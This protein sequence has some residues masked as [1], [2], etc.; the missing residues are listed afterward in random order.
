MPHPFSI[1]HFCP[2]CGS[3]RFVV[4]NAKSKRCEACGFVY[5]ANPQAATVG[6][7][8]N[9]RGELLVVRRAKD[10]ARGTLDL[11]GGFSDMGETSE[12]GVVRE[13]REETGLTVSVRR[14]LFSLPNTYMFSGLLEH[15]MDMFYL[16]DVVGAAPARAADD[17]AEVLWLPLADLDPE[18]FGLNSI[19]RAIPK[20]KELLIHKS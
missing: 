12:E 5:Y 3:P 8:V 1:F 6:V 4:H 9:E 17:A 2:V 20:I 14:F 15:T 11:P 13:L 16:L 19:R 18:A 7:V 10:P